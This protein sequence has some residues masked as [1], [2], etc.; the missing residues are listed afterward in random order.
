VTLPN[1]LVI[2]AQKA[3]TTSLFRYLGEH[4]DVFVPAVKEPHFF[5]GHVAWRRGL[6]W[7]ESL[8]DGAGDALAVGEASTSYTM[9]PAV[10]GVPERV[11]G[12]L[13]EA[14][15]VYVVR[16]PVERMRSSWV[17][18]VSRGVERRPVGEAL[19]A[20]RRYLDMSRYAHQLEQY[21][22]WFPPSQLLVVTAEDL[23]DR[24]AETL[25]RVLEFLGVQAGREPPNL[26]TEFHPSR[27]KV[28]PRPLLRRLGLGP[29]VAGPAAARLPGPLRAGVRRVA[30][31]PLA[32]GEGLLDDEVR[33]RLT[34]LVRDDVERLRA[35]LGPGFDGWGIA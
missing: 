22:A 10:A 19:L 2:G 13:P 6:A 27:D 15:L 11:A 17:H 35:H 31:R 3:G 33:A 20:D 23:R 25:R 4:P 8:F 32:P 34:D 24:R 14:R 9:H 18:A 30:L 5:D 7:Y 1:F 28:A 26:G 21:L 29:A 12:V 16:H